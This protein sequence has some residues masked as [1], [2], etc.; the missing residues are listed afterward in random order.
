M[1]SHVDEGRV[2]MGFVDKELAIGAQGMRVDCSDLEAMGSCEKIASMKW[3][4]SGGI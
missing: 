2:G 4:R 3:R 1:P